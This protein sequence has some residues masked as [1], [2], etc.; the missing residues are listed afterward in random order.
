MFELGQPRGEQTMKALRD[1][2]YSIGLSLCA[3]PAFAQETSGLVVCLDSGGKIVQ[4]FPSDG[5]QQCDAATTAYLLGSLVDVQAGDGLTAEV[6]AGKAV[7]SVADGLAIPPACPAGQV[8]LSDGQG[9]WVC[10]PPSS[11]ASTNPASKIWVIP[12]LAYCSKGNGRIRIACQGSGSQTV[13]HLV[14]PGENNANYEC[15]IFDGDGTYRSGYSQGGS[16]NPGAWNACG[17]PELA[18]DAPVN[19][20]WAIVRSDQPILVNAQSRFRAYSEDGVESV[21]AQV[22]A[23]PVDCSNNPEGYK[24]VCLFKP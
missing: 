12:Y 9:G 20:V 24:F 15:L 11:L 19:Y 5:Q 21:A 4:A 14:N 17:S 6:D 22:E 1:F 23:Y 13:I 8:A 18:R 10:T 7:I 2:L 3:L 16:L